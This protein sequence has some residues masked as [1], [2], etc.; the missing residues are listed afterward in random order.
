ML[1]GSSRS[2]QLTIS[3]TSSSRRDSGLRCERPTVRGWSRCRRGVTLAPPSILT[4]RTSSDARTTWIAYGQSKTANALF[5][6]AF[7]ARGEAHRVRA[8]SVHPGA[9]ATTELM[10]S[11]PEGERRA[12]LGASSVSVA[13]QE[14][15]AGGGD[16][17]L[18]RY[19]HTTP[20][21]GRRLLRGRGYRRSGARRLTR[22]TWREAVGKGS[23][24]GRAAMEE[25]PSVDRRDVH[26]VTL[27]RTLIRRSRQHSEL[28]YARK[29]GRTK[30]QHHRR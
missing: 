28:E 5:A 21:H 25:E 22:A 11:M 20:R 17:R 26:C 8:F 14:R 15:G 10:R 30:R 12:A 18:V 2:S 19:E 27:A 6:V 4:I 29:Y 13:L 7:D 23:R 9:V 24:P 1:A 3:A 16:E